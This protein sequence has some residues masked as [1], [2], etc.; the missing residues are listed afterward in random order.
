M[1]GSLMLY[2]KGHE[3]TNAPTL[4]LLLLC[5]VEGLSSRTPGK[6]HQP[7]LKTR[8]VSK[9]LSASETSELSHSE[10]AKLSKIPQNILK[11]PH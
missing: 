11:T 4:W 9:L 6:D 7:L 2:L 8:L 10:T 3:D 1:L 5:L